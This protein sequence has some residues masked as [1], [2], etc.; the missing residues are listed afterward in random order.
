MTRA[1]M[2]LVAYVLLSLSAQA[3]DLGQWDSDPET[4]AWFK[5]L[6]QPDK[7]TVPCCGEADAYWCDEISVDGSKVFCKI[8]DDR[9]DAPLRRPHIEMGTPFEIPSYKYKYDAGNPTGHAVLFVGA[10]GIYCFVQGGGA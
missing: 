4:K 10:G 6:M 8:T 1:I 7:P 5:T 3:R 2:A 9:D